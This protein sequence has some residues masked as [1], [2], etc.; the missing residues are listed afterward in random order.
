MNLTALKQKIKKEQLENILRTMVEEEVE[1]ELMTIWA[2][3]DHEKR[4]EM[5]LEELRTM[6]VIEVMI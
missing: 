6:G 1:G 4:K 3:F 5:I 2:E